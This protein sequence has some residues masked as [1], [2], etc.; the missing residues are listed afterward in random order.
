MMDYYRPSYRTRGPLASFVA[1]TPPATRILI[2][3]CL[4]V[5]GLQGIVRLASGDG[6]AYALLLRLFGLTPY[7]FI[8]GYIYQAVSYLFLHGGLWHLLLNLL[9]LWMFGSEMERYWGTRRFLIYYAVC[10]VGAALTTV[11][12]GP[13]EPVPTIGASGAILGLLLAYGMTFPDRMVLFNFIIPM[14]AKYFVLVIIVMQIF[15]FWPYLGSRIAVAAHLGGMLFGYLYLKRA[16]RVRELW[17]EI[18]WRVRRRRFRVIDR[19]EG[20]PTFH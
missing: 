10:G 18:R 6:I 12:V 20:P 3:A 13:F 19:E 17:A 2:L 15:S 1:R 11:A 16:W 9:T 8:H 7:L 4:G 14:R 5:G